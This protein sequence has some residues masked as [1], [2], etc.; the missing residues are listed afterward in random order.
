MN[1]L[2]NLIPTIIVLGVLIL[3]HEWGHF[4]ACRLSRVR[5]DKFSIGFGPELF[6]FQG[7]ET[8]YTVSLFPFGGYVKPAGESFSDLSPVGAK[9]GDYLAAPV[10]KRIFIVVSGVLMNYLLSFL[11]FVGIFMMG[12]PVPLAQIGGFVEGY[13]AETSGLAE[14]DRIRAVEGKAVTSWADLTSTLTEIQ[15]EEVVLEVEREGRVKQ[16]GVRV[17]IEPV[18][19]ILGKTHILARLGITPDPEA[20]QIERF[21]LTAAIREAAVTEAYLAGLTYKA[22]YYLVTGRLSLKTISGP[23]GIMAMT[24]SAAKMGLVYVLHLTAVLG[25]SLAVINLLPIPALDGGHLVFLLI[26]VIQG[27]QVSPRVQ[28]RATQVGFAF[29]ILLMIL[30]IYNDLLN[31]QVFDRVKAVLGR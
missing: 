6:H 15:R 24:G 11:L 28:E 30:V 25:I 27:R 13:P 7:R 1:L 23:I 12:R 3:I 17:R 5:V 31:L 19:D 4:I 8:R 16:L 10:L 20:V 26:E 2:A 29:L 22:L 14:G 9:P 21:G 18:K